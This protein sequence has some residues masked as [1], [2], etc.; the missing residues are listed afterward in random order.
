MLIRAAPSVRRL[1]SLAPNAGTL[2]CCLVAGLGQRP[3]DVT[4]KNALTSLPVARSSA[5]ARQVLQQNISQSANFSVRRTT[6]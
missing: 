6:R 1:G 4:T 2:M 5:V 3:G